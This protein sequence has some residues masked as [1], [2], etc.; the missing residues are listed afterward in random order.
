MVVG[1]DEK[2]T[3]DDAGKVVLQAPGKDVVSI[4]DISNREAPRIVVSLPLMN[5]VFGPPTNLAITPDERV[6][7]VANSMAWER[8]GAGFKAVP[9]NKIYVIDLTANPPR[10]VAYA[11][12]PSFFVYVNTAAVKPRVVIVEK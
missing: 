12:S 3:W 2:V 1:I 7:I 5:S 11:V 10:Q 9:D 4:V 8:D 6:A